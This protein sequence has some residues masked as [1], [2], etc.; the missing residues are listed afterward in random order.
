ML[1]KVRIGIIANFLLVREAL[2]SLLMKDARYAVAG[3][4]GDGM[5]AVRTAETWNVDLIIL[6]LLLYKLSGHTMLAELKK[7]LPNTPI[8]AIST[9]NNVEYVLDII[10]AGATGYCRN[11]D[12]FSDIRTAIDILLAGKYYLTPCAMD[13]M[14]RLVLAERG[15]LSRPGNGHI[16]SLSGRENEILNLI[17]EGYRTKDIA[18]YLYL[19]KRTVEKH[20]YNIMKKLDIHRLSALVHFKWEN[21]EAGLKP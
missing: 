8:L 1:N 20:R 16:A 13:Q 7:R 6:D 5:E 17:T 21:R 12:S 4:A 15:N 11:S 9:V 10:Q 2:K 18:H 19:S 14:I 3:E